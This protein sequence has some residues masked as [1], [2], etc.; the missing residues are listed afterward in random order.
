VQAARGDWAAGELWP[1]GNVQ[2]LNLRTG[3]TS[4]VAVQTPVD[5]VDRNGWFV[6]GTRMYSGDSPVALD[7]FEDSQVYVSDLSDT[8]KAVGSILTDDGIEAQ[9]GSGALMW[10]CR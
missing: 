2:R 8:G 7:A 1:S 9:K 3:A 6:T 5:A 4:Q 10:S